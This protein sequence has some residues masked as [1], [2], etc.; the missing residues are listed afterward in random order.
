M[1]AQRERS[2]PGDDAVSTQPPATII[3]EGTRGPEDDFFC[4]KYQVWYK[5]ADCVY[6]Q[7]NETFP[8]CADCFQGHINSRSMDRGIAPP[9]FLGANP[10]GTTQLSAPGDLL[11]LR[12]RSRSE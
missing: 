10:P 5:A 4:H 6:R 8:G 11:Q 3:P 12:R 1:L 7:R 2:S 9:R